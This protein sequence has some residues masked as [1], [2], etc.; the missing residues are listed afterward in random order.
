MKSAKNSTDRE[1]YVVK[2]GG[3]VLSD[4]YAYVYQAQR[5]LEFSKDKEKVYVVLSAR[6]GQT[7][8]L[9]D[10]LCS[11]HKE[12]ESLRRLLKKG[13]YSSPKDAERFDNENI[14]NYLLRGE[15][16]STLRFEE[17]LKNL[18]IAPDVL[19]QGYSFPVIANGRYLHADVDFEASENT[20]V[21]DSLESKIVLIPGFGAQNY[22]REIVLLGRNASDYVAA[23]IGRLD[24]RVKEIVYLKDVGGIYEN[25]GT[26]KQRFIEKIKS[27]ELHDI[28]S[29][30]VLDR[31]CLDCINGNCMRVQHCESEIGKGGT[32]I[33]H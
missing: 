6:K 27:S 29:S 2:I 26:G 8:E 30:K 14:A 7:D 16:E 9:A 25:Y 1:I 19:R 24:Q 20:G 33:V 4:D 15:I 17:K 13:D 31:R 18:G 21:L 11:S 10:S 28:D 12:R 3:S 23:L 22:K 32:L 5:I